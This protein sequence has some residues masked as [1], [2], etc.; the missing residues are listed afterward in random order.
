LKRNGA[1]FLWNGCAVLAEY[2]GSSKSGALIPDSNI[3]YSSASVFSA[4]FLVFLLP[5]IILCPVYIDIIIHIRELHAKYLITVAIDT[6]FTGF[7]CHI[8]N[9]I[10]HFIK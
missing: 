7:N 10:C 6:A 9:V 2:A 1:P 4:C 3:Y 5:E 8:E